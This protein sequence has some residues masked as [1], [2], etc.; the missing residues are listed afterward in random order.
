MAEILF[1]CL[2]NIGNNNTG[3]A[4]P[5]LTQF[6]PTPVKISSID[7]LR[8]KG[9]RFQIPGLYPRPREH[10]YL[11]RSRSTDGVVGVSSSHDK[12]RQFFPILQELIIPYFIG[13]DARKIPTL[14]DEVYRFRSNYKLSGLA[15]WCCMAWVEISLL[16]LLGKHAQKSICQ[17]LGGSDRDKVPVY[18]SSTSRD[19]T[20]EEEVDWVGKRLDETGVRA[21][22]LKI[23]GRMSNNADAIPQRTEKLVA[24]ARKVFGDDMTIGVDG[25][26]SFDAEKAIEIGEFLESYNISFFEEPCPFDD[27]VATQK[28]TQSLDLTIAGGEQETSFA[29]FQYMIDNSVVN[30]LQPDLIYNGGLI[31]TLR[32]A[33]AA[34]KARVPITIHNARLGFDLLYM[35]QFSGLLPNVYIEHHARPSKPPTWFTPALK[36]KNGMM[37]VPQGPGLGVEIDPAFLRRSHKLQT[38][39]I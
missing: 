37:N 29:R 4:D 31:R 7:I 26:G 23:G 15:L 20:P 32:V 3:L 14:I 2:E 25:N 21:V 1:P 30:V 27:F 24:R 22:K 28:V 16:D 10:T 39:R 18:L 35:A 33:K 9:S 38:F 5:D 17:L 13:K 34:V 19:T 11:I 6:C 8:V 36:I 12:I